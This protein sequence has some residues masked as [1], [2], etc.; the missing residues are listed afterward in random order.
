MSPKQQAQLDYE[1]HRFD[2]KNYPRKPTV[3]DSGYYLVVSEFRNPLDN[4]THQLLK[5]SF[6]V[7]FS[8]LALTALAP[9]LAFIALL[10]KLDSRGPALY[11]PIRVGRRDKPFRCLKFR[12]M[13]HIPHLSTGSTKVNDPRVTRVGKI[14]R[15]TSLDELPQFVNVLLGE[16]SVVGPRPHRIQLDEEFREEIPEY[17]LRKLVRPGITGLAQINGWRG[18]TDT[19]VRKYQ[20]TKHDLRYIQ[21]WSIFLDLKIILRTILS[22]QVHQNAF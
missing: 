22:P 12:T 1:S 2:P 8:L 9:L 6:D 20:R 7:V 3:T 16:M 4:Q 19:R 10:V 21:D 13:K 18:P 11:R 5:R 15:A 14:L 17:D